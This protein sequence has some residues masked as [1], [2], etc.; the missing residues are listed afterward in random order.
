[1]SADLAGDDCSA[2]FGARGERC[3]EVFSASSAKSLVVG[4]A[5]SITLSSVVSRHGHGSVRRLIHAVISILY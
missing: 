3:E 5:V 4:I 1:M 2:A